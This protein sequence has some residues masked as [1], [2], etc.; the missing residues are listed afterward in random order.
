M[1]IEFGSAQR[2]DL[3]ATDAKMCIRYVIIIKYTVVENNGIFPVTFSNP[4]CILY[5]SCVCVRAYNVHN[6]YMWQ[7]NVLKSN[8]MYAVYTH[9]CIVYLLLYY[10]GTCNKNS[11]IT[12]C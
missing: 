1:Y 12:L 10:I 5:A 11:T 4:L 8:I 7:L 3:N 2:K 9:I 6:V